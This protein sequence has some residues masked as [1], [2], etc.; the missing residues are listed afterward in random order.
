MAATIRPEAATAS[1]V[2]AAFRPLVPGSIPATPRASRA[3]QVP[4]SARRTNAAH[5]RTDLSATSARL[6]G[7]ALHAVSEAV[8]LFG[9]G[10]AV[11]GYGAIEFDRHAAVRSGDGGVNRAFR[12]VF[13]EV[14]SD[15]RQQVRE[16]SHNTPTGGEG[17][18]TAWSRVRAY[19]IQN[20]QAAQPKEEWCA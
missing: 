1:P 8:G 5:R 20:P 10:Q 2:R 3:S 7:S 14:P 13:I 18:M 12:S 4:A 15:G 9:G 16:Q 17:L 19:P 6:S 11:A